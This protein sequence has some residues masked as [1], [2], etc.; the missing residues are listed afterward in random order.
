MVGAARLAT[1]GRLRHA[2]QPT[3]A[4]TA[5]SHLRDRP[6]GDA[7]QGGLPQSEEQACSTGL[8]DRVD[9][10]ALG[11][12]LIVGVLYRSQRRA[13]GASLAHTHLEVVMSMSWRDRIATLLVATATLLY[14]L[15]LVGPLAGLT[16]GSVAIIVL[17]LGFLASASAVV[18][19][20]TA[21]L[22]GSRV[23]LVLASA[24]GLVA[25]ACG[26]MTVTQATEVALAVLVIVT[27]GLWAA[28]T[29]RHTI[30]RRSSAVAMR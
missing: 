10:I 16:A 2:V 4:G 3:A 18:P 6:V 11:L 28:A 22:S 19:G 15:W 8:S 5:A 12:T 29:V 23:Y 20:F 9:T 1:C 27:I 21:L 17:A 24:G 14:V 25:L 13:D 26:V 30:V 7:S